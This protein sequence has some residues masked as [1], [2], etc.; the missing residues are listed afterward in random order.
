MRPDAYHATNLG[1]RSVEESLLPDALPPALPYPS[2]AHGALTRSSGTVSSSARTLAPSSSLTLGLSKGGFFASIGRKASMKRERGLSLNSG[3]TSMNRPPISG[4]TSSQS[5]PA[6]HLP[7]PPKLLGGPRAPPHSNRLQ[8]TTSIAISSPTPSPS[9][10]KTRSEGIKSRNLSS[11]PTKYESA[12]GGARPPLH[13][14]RS[15]PQSQPQPQLQLQPLQSRS[16][17][18]YR[19]PNAPDTGIEFEAS[20]QK[21]VDVLPHVE[22]T[23]L[24]IYLRKSGNDMAAISAYLEDERTGRVVKSI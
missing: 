9:P 22:R 14:A 8:K 11:S 16:S 15:A 2:L 10:T 21:L 18:I 17:L 4:S 6:I 20:L 5:R 13:P 19:N 1:A 7:T 23:T 12:V 24:A 3:P